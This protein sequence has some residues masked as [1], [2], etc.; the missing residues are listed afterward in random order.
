MKKPTIKVKPFDYQPNRA[1]HDQTFK[2]H[3]TPEDLARS[4][5][6]PVE[7]LEDPAA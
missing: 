2:A 4:V 1:D 3:T 7:V 5:L 6:S